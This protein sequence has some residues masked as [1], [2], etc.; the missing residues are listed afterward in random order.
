MVSYIIQRL[1]YMVVTLAMVSVVTFAVIELPPGDF[2][3]A[4][5]ANLRASGDSLD[6]AEIASLRQRFGLGLPLYQRYYKWISDIVL[7]GDFGYSFGWNKPVS[8]L[9]WERVG[10]TFMISFAALMVTWVLGFIIGVYSAVRQYSIGDYLFTTFSFIGLGIPDFLLALV[11]LWIGFKYFGES[12]G[13]LFSRDFQTAPWSMAKFWDMLKHLWV[14]LVILGTG[15]TA[16]M[17]RIMRANLLDEL[18]KPYVETA[19]AKGVDER[20][21]ILKYPVRLALNP[22]ISTAGWALPGLINGATIISIVLSLPTTGPILLNALLNQDMYLAAS[23]ILI[24]SAL[25]VIGTMISDILL[26][27]LDPRIRYQ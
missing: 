2:L 9:I 18:R 19:R 20:R 7:H 5:V 1:L 10:L 14:P 16:G 22:F 25:T 6:E 27:W 17:I 26:A 8:E 11:L 23:F 12:L 13:G 21:L 15:G 24:L 3:D 4:Y